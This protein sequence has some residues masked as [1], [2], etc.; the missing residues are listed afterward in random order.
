MLAL[1]WIGMRI[2]ECI[3]LLGALLLLAGIGIAQRASGE[4]GAQDE[5]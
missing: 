5:R 4:K 1:R 3:A 2:G